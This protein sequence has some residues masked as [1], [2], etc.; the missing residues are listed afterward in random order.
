MH[1]VL[2]ADILEEAGLP[3]AKTAYYDVIL[4]YG[5]GEIDLGLYVVI[6]VIDDTVIDRYFGDDSGNIYEGDGQGS[7][8]AQGT[9]NL[10]ERSFLKENNTDEA[11]WSDIKEL[12][13]VLNSSERTS[14][15]AAWRENLE[16]IFDVDVFLEWLG[17][18]AIL[19][20]WDTYG[21]MSHNFYLYDNPATGQ[22]TWISWDHNQV[23]ESGGG[24][25]A[26]NARAVQG[27]RPGR[28]L[29]I[30]RDE[31]TSQWPLIRNLLDDPVY[32]EKYV[33]YIEITLN[34]AFDPDRLE[35]KIN[36]LQKLIAPFVG[37]NKTSNFQSA[38]LQLVNRIDT[39]YQ[40]AQSYIGGENK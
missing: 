15:P 30:G 25:G 40:A 32:H 37:Q 19:Q 16:S 33:D 39:Q 5:E 28:T 21:S 10:I 14:D 11:D 7:S 31:V 17:I 29:T 27:I 24:I 12:Y 38:V 18:G 8:L 3:A 1:D 34:G 23:L 22:L 26:P 4:D 35:E 36:R 2:A 9:Y 20:H 13:N 6:E